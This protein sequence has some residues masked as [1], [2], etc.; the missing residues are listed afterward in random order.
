MLSRK[1]NFIILLVCVLFVSAIKSSSGDSPKILNLYVNSNIK[2]T[3]SSECGLSYANSC[4]NIV[5]AMKYFLEYIGEKGDK[6]LPLALFLEDGIYL[7]KDN[8]LS[9]GLGLN[10]LLSTY[11][12]NSKKVVFD[13][14]GINV[15][16]FDYSIKD[17]NTHPTTN[18]SLRLESIAFI[19]F[20]SS[21]YYILSSKTVKNNNKMSTYFEFNSCLFYNCKNVRFSVNGESK[22][23]N[24]ILFDKTFF[25]NVDFP[26]NPFSSPYYSTMISS[27]SFDKVSFEGSFISYEE[28]TNYVISD[29]TFTKVSYGTKIQNSSFIHSGPI[30]IKKSSF[31]FI[32]DPKISTPSYFLKLSKSNYSDVI[33]NEF[34]N[35]N[36]GFVEINN[37]VTTI[38]GNIISKVNAESTVI[39]V[40]NSDVY[41][42][43]NGF[44]FANNLN[45]VKL[46]DCTGSYLRFL[47]NSNNEIF[48]SNTICKD[49]DLAF[50]SKEIC[51]IQ[52][53][54]T[55]SSTTTT[56]K[57]DRPNSSIDS[58]SVSYQLL[59]IILIV[60]SLLN[61]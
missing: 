13:G 16:L 46:V 60:I 3:Y 48:E 44:N 28:G 49:C 6:N 10:I 38:R 24:Y 27:S 32:S 61:L 31:S 50:D 54:T 29:T 33:E 36:G 26:E 11:K 53:S 56:G 34:E 20:N 43:L 7:G 25:L 14:T 59:I 37:V 35:F 45:G 5:D 23:L 40:S 55:T 42:R 9:S 52:P 15:N 51:H 21:D 57:D 1:F 19:N 41:F 39:K 18:T 58:K 47:N 22:D 8:Y 2:N 4:N 17:E 12:E 30:S